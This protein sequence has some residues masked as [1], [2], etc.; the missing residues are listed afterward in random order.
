[1]AEG[2]KTHV[3]MELTEEQAKKRDMAEKRLWR[4]NLAM[5][6]MHLVW[7]VICLIVG[8]G[9]SRAGEF[10]IPELTSYPDW[11]GGGRRGPVAAQQLRGLIPFVALTSVFAWMSAAAHFCVLVCFKQYVKD[12]RAGLNQ[13]RWLEYAGSS[14][15]MIVLISM[16]FG[17]WDSHLLFQIGACNACM[18]FF[19]YAFEVQNRPGNKIDWSNFIFGC[20]AGACPWASV[21]SYVFSTNGDGV[22]GFVWGILAAYLIMF[23]TF[24]IN[25]WLQYA[26]VGAWYR[27]EAGGFPGAGYYF[28]EKVYQVLSLVAK[29]LLLW[30]VVGGCGQ[31]SAYT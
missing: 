17:I 26:Q 6:I 22:P 28:G 30:L 25:M 20:F 29:T 3:T 8:L 4:W 27:D 5:G 19:G 10:R 15:L 18:N 31:P 16:L 24:P 11:S 21:L 7:A 13:I 9:K 1:M 12:L 23:N 14:S 2:Q